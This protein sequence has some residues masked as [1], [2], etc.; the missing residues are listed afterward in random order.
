L[1]A[2]DAADF[3][4]SWRPHV[5][6]YEPMALIG[7]LLA[8]IVEVPAVRHL[9]TMDFTAQSDDFSRDLEGPLVAAYGFDR[10]PV[11]GDMTIDPC[12]PHLQIA[13]TLPRQLIRFVPYNGPTEFPGWLREPPVRSRVCVTW[14]TTLGHLG[15]MA[16]VPRVV[17]A[18]ADLDVEVV[19]A[20]LDTHRELFP[21][22]PAN[23][24]HVGPIALDLL[25]PTCD[26]VIHQG[27]G[28]TTMTALVHGVPQLIVPSVPDQVFNAKRL[29]AA[30]AGRYT[31]SGDRASTEEILAEARIVLSDPRCRR[32]A[33]ELRRELLAQPTPAE[34]IPV[35]EELATRQ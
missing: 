12:P 30:G 20:V 23:V 19:L 7:P 21:D 11:N 26:A 1:M 3:A 9:W 22:L 14:G 8:R 34:V 13:D 5:V 17:R 6:V 27:G 15:R 31:P 10:L 18:L 4:K 29:A 16:H 33:R 24:G 28:G 35:L 32:A 2:R 25:L